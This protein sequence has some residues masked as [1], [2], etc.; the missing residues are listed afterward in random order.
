MRF[1]AA[2]LRCCAAD[3]RT[4]SAALLRANKSGL[5]LTPHTVW[6]AV[7]TA[8]HTLYGIQCTV[9]HRR[10]ARGAVCV[11]RRAA[12]YRAASI[13][14][15]GQAACILLASRSKIPARDTPRGARRSLG[16]ERAPL[17]THGNCSAPEN[18]CAAYQLAARASANEQDATDEE[19]PPEAARLARLVQQ[20]RPTLRLVNFAL[21][22][23]AKAARSGPAKRARSACKQCT[24]SLFGPSNW[25]ETRSE[26][27]PARR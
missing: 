5:L 26:L 3:R 15:G 12:A 7:R 25:L 20:T 17:V 27:V 14:A 4:C 2:L 22:R 13:C 23:R 16:R 10:T 8:H 18:R 21:G 6:H 11:T 1:S 9:Q 19:R 24:G